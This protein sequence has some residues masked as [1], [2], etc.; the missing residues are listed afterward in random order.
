MKKSIPFGIGAI[1]ILMLVLVLSGCTTES[2]KTKSNYIFCND[3][4]FSCCV[5][6]TQT[7]S[8]ILKST[9]LLKC[10]D[11][12][13]NCELVSQNPI[14]SLNVVYAGSENCRIQKPYW[15][16]FLPIYICDDMHEISGTK[17]ILKGENIWS[18]Q[19]GI[20]I[21]YK[22][23]GQKLTFCGKA[24]CTQGVDIKSDSCT[25]QTNGNIYDYNGEIKAGTDYQSTIS[26]TA[27]YGQCFLSWNSGNRH[28][29]GTVD[30]QCSIDSD[31]DGHTYGNK[32]CYARTLQTYGCRDLSLPQSVTETPDGYFGGDS[33]INDPKEYGT[34]QKSRCE[35]ISAKSV[36]CCGDS[37]CGSN[38]FCDIETFTCK[39]SI[40]CSRDSDCGVSEQCDIEKKQIVKPVCESGQ[41]IKE[42]VQPVD[43]CSD[44]DCANGYYCD[45]DYKCKQSSNPKTACPYECCPALNTNDNE[46]YFT[47]PCPPEKYCTETHVCSSEESQCKPLWAIGTV[48]ILPNLACDLGSTFIWIM[49]AIGGLIGFY[50]TF[51]FMNKKDKKAKSLNWTLS[52]IIGLI[53]GFFTYLYW[54]AILIILA[55]IVIGKIAI[56]LI[57]K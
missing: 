54:W 24:G 48:T 27:P 57:L 26:Y 52:I 51:D 3:Y 23:N 19:D 18:S 50:F 4:E 46:K 37:D 42:E 47:K 16:L 30:E 5:P 1:M 21:Q 17:Q 36:Q 34:L 43:C 39:A 12:A 2:T 8:A 49:T 14:D 35:I 28:I 40:S 10:P 22:V 56:K 53:T 55:L 33:L 41:C 9:E 11:N 25:F 20:Q 44:N 13:I 31:C 7:N 32:E 29:C 38:S 45:S 6:T 15:H